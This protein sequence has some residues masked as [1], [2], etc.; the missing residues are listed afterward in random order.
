MPKLL[1]CHDESDT[2]FSNV[3]VTHDFKKG[4][5]DDMAEKGLIGVIQE[6]MGFMGM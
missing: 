6:R 3:E 2:E 1:L 4:S 5:Y